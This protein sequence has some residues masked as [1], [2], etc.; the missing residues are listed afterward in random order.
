MKFTGMKILLLPLLLTTFAHASEWYDMQMGKMDNLGHLPI[1]EQIEI[2][3]SIV[4]IGRRD[5]L[6][7]EHKTVLRR[8]QSMLIA[9][10]EHAE[11]YEKKIKDGMA[12]IENQPDDGLPRRTFNAPRIEI[13]QI[14]EQIPSPQI[15]RVLGDFLSDDRGGFE[16]KQGD[17]MPTADDIA[18]G[19]LRNSGY[20]S[21]ALYGLIDNPLTPYR[22]YFIE[23]VDVPE[24]RLWYNQVKAGNRTFRFK[25]DSTEYNLNGPA[26]STKTPDAKRSDPRAITNSPVESKKESGSKAPTITAII[27]VLMIGAGYWIYRKK[28]TAS[29]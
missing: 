9:I 14:L 13:F 8:S 3:S 7:D 19:S 10:P 2:L 27:V 12:L 23:N 21:I 25:G 26:G 6:N 4:R 24:W 1:P 18:H 28:C 15:V 5:E 20:A 17:P 16:Y 29:L 11:Y 22:G